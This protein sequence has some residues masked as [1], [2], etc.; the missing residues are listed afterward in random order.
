MHSLKILWLE[1][2]LL[3]E[4]PI[5]SHLAS[6][7]TLEEL[8]MDSHHAHP[9]MTIPQTTRRFSSLRR[10]YLTGLIYGPPP[11]EFLSYID[12]ASLQSLTLKWIHYNYEDERTG[13]RT[14][15]RFFS[16]LATTKPRRLEHVTAA[17]RFRGSDE[18]DLERRFLDSGSQ[19]RGY[20][21]CLKK[22]GKYLRSLC[23]ITSL[24]TI[25]LEID[26][27]FQLSDDFLIQLASSLPHLEHLSTIPDVF[28]AFMPVKES[29]LPT[30]SG[31]LALVA[32]CP[33]LSTLRLAVRTAFPKAREDVG[34]ATTGPRPVLLSSNSMR[35]FDLFTTPVSD[36]VEASTVSAFLK[37][38]F[39]TLERFRVALRAPR[40]PDFSAE[41]RENAC[42]Q[43][44]GIVEEMLEAQWDKGMNIDR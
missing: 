15:R 11:V 27:V 30:F 40:D 6:L 44:S 14:L 8:W 20:L 31:L 29:A 17:F 9:D 2:A 34:D 32:N 22:G 41:E 1:D 10:L 24:R 38:T 12:P 7:S 43:W 5:M 16:V 36:G 28:Y 42:A 39:P 4:Y 35:S 37:S 33:R 19:G 3:A 25:K 26:V 23:D 18:L 21:R 13:P